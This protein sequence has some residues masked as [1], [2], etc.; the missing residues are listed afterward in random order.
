[1]ASL[2]AR[3]RKFIGNRR[4]AARRKA[5][6]SCSISVIEPN[7]RLKNARQPPPVAGRTRDVCAS[8]LAIEV[9]AIRVGSRYLTAPDSRL[10]VLLELPSGSIEFEG[11]TTRYERIEEDGYAK[12]YLIAVNVRRLSE[13]DRGRYFDFLRSLK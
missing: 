2:I 9:G 13:D 1:M 11:A 10:S 8:H 6:L 7:A 4:Y 5:E 3:F 12:G